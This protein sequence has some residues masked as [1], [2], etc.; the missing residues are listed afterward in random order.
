[1]LREMATRW[2][3]RP[4]SQWE[5]TEP[6]GPWLL[7]TLVNPV[8]T[9]PADYFATRPLAPRFHLTEQTRE[10]LAKLGIHAPPDGPDYR[11]PQPYTGPIARKSRSA[12]A[13]MYK[14]R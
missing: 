3:T 10:A 14:L 1:M 7:V 6:D 5:Q 12:N 9:T 8:A 13:P 11:P 4:H 2:P